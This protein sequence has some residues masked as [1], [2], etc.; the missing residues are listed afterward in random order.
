MWMTDDELTTSYRNRK[1]KEDHIRVLAE[2]NNCPKEEIKAR[3][4]NL[5]VIEAEKPQKHCGSRA[6]N[7][8]NGEFENKTEGEKPSKAQKHCGSEAT[9]EIQKMKQ[10]KI[11]ESIKKMALDRLDEIQKKIEVYE[12]EKKE[13]EAEYKEVSEFI[14]LEV[15]P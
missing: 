9:G 12:R 8:Q 13:L 14:G 4:I 11:P 2:L 5:G 1:G 6:L 10:R 3:L 15:A 7:T